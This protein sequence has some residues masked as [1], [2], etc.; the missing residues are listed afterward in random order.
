MLFNTSLQIFFFFDNV[1]GYGYVYVYVYVYVCVY[2]Y[3]YVFGYGYVY[4]FCLFSLNELESNKKGMN[5]NFFLFSFF[6]SSVSS[7]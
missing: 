4:E 5:K 2:V 3:V 6:L 7:V 1:Y